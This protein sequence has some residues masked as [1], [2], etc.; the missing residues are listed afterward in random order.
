MLAKIFLKEISHLAEQILE[1]FFRSSPGG[2]YIPL[3]IRNN[4]TNSWNNYFSSSTGGDLHD[5]AAMDTS[6]II[7]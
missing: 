7:L 6:G 2:V 3:L 5:F 1:L 4:Q